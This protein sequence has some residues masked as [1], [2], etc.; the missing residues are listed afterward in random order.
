MELIHQDKFA[1]PGKADQYIDT[2]LI[3]HRRSATSKRQGLI[4][5]IHGLMPRGGKGDRYKYWHN[6]PQLL[7]EEFPDC[8]V[9]LYYYVSGISRF[10]FSKS[11]PLPSEAE[12]LSTELVGLSE[13]DRVVLVG[14]SM[15]GI[16]A[17][18]GLADLYVQI[19]KGTRALQRIAGVVLV[20]SPTLGSLR[21]PW[22]S[23][24]FS[25][26]MRALYPHNSYLQSIWSILSNH[27]DPVF[28][29]TAAATGARNIP[30]WALLASNDFW[31][32]KMT[33]SSTMPQDQV[34][35]I[36]GTH[37]S[38]VA[39]ANS[40]HAGYRYIRDRIKESFGLVPYE[41]QPQKE[42]AFEEAVERDSHYIHRL[43]ESWF[44]EGVTPAQQIAKLIGKG[45]F[46]FVVKEIEL[47]GGT[48]TESIKGYFCVFPLKA[49]AKDAL[50]KGDLSG[51]Q[52]SIDHVEA[53]EEQPACVYIGAVVGESD[54][55]RALIMLGLKEFLIGRK[56]S[57]D[58]EFIAYPLR[59]DGVRIATDYGFRPHYQTSSGRTLWR[60]VGP[61][62]T[63]VRRSR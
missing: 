42:I 20:A 1:D 59:D 17:R 49:G 38:V 48:R 31:V 55:A 12:T 51:A 54:Y 9:G 8:D 13:Y 21:V 60:H 3:V 62:F 57:E 11:L 37:S 52:V 25:R 30:V 19:R 47:D 36:R 40:N 10:K 35:R 45:K 28:R 44:G 2:P 43:A 24:L 29:G 5:L 15:G 58:V 14:H 4:I 22:W 18:G 50:I 27:C 32:D 33:A 23:V 16:L 56:Y 53:G 7:F 39:A 26:D 41:M 6:M 61:A 34:H 46:F 63:R